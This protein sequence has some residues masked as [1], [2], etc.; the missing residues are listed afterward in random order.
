MDYKKDRQFLALQFGRNSGKTMAQM[1]LGNVIRRLGKRFKFLDGRQFHD[2][3]KTRFN[4]LF[5]DAVQ[6]ITQ[7]AAFHLISSQGKK[8]VL[9]IRFLVEREWMF[10]LKDGI[11]GNLRIGTVR[12]NILKYDGVG[13]E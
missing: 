8:R 2:F 11:Q 1:S 3:I 12:H 13:R 5:I 10:A 9:E 6:I 7:Q 4:Q